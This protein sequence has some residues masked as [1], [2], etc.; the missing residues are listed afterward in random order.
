[1]NLSERHPVAFAV[2]VICDYKKIVTVREPV[3]QIYDGLHSA[4]GFVTWRICLTKDHYPLF[5]KGIVLTGRFTISGV[6]S[7]WCGQAVSYKPF[8]KHCLSNIRREQP[9]LRF[10][11]RRNEWREVSSYW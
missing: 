2:I 4:T 6:L 11:M 3:D 8:G 5:H 9:S 10:G 7:N 1:M